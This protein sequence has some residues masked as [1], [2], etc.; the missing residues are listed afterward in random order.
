MNTAIILSGGIGTRIK[1]EGCPKQYIEVCGK[2][3][4]WYTLRTVMQE[5]ELSRWVVVAAAEWREEITGLFQELKKELGREML[6]M[7]FA[8]PGSNRQYSIL[9]ALRVIEGLGE[10]S[11]DAYVAVIDAVRPKMS[12]E[13][14]HTCMFRAYEGD[15]AVPVLP[16]KDTVYLSE[17]GKQITE[18]IDRTKVIA[19]QA[20]EV[21]RF[22]EYLNANERLSEQQMLD[23]QGSAQPAVAAGMNILSVDGDEANYK[24]TTDSDLERF[25]E[26]CGRE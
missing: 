16:M 11:D 3:M 22:R 5:H 18:N 1:S 20:P 10:P 2:P 26:E 4:I 9:N 15:G 14:L 12:R 8:E 19:G 17:D 21:F 23:I 13:L 7:L 6:P 24:I 25:R